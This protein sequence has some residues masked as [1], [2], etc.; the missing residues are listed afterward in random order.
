MIVIAVANQKGGVGKT[1]TTVNLAAALSLLGLKC[2]IVDMD[3]QGHAGQHLGIELEKMDEFGEDYFDTLSFLEQK[4]NPIECVYATSLQNLFCI[5]SNTNL[6][7]FNQKP[8]LENRFKLRE[9]LNSQDFQESLNL[10]FVFLDCQPSLSLLTLNALTASYGILIPVQ[11]EFLALEGLSQLLLTFKD[12]KAKL[13]PR[14]Q[15]LGILLNMFD[16]RNRLSEKVRQELAANFSAEI[17]QTVIP[18]SVRLAEA[19]SFGQSI[20]EYTGNSEIAES[21][22]KLA[23]EFLQKVSYLEL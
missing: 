6:A 15:V 22:Q 19:P 5:P 17:F 9:L 12:I 2:L 4:V 8:P 14:L 18:R 1:T 10:D 3:P 21:Y 7:K 23:Q 11:A 16:K 13:H 20:F